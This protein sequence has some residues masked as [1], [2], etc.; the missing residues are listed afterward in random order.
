MKKYLLLILSSI[1][2]SFIAKQSN[3]D[4]EQ[5]VEIRGKKQFYIS[6]GTAKPVVVFI[7]GLG[8]TM[9]D[10]Q[11]VQTKISKY[12][13]TI[14]YDRA[15]IGKS[16]SFNNERNLENISVE[17]KE[18]VEKI[19]LDKPFVLVGHSRGGLIARYFVSKY[20]EKVCGLILI[21]P[22]IPEH[23]WKKRELRTETE[24]VEFDK[25]YNSFCSDSVNYTATIRNEFKNTFTT[26]SALVEG[27]G[28]P[29]TIP[30][31][32]IGSNKITKDKYSKEENRI[33]VEFLKSYLKINP[34]IKLILTNKSGHFIHDDEP[35]L[36]TKEIVA[37]INK[38]KADAKR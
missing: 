25:F 7:T 19:G 20:P 2:F 17:L 13:K 30:I 28:F 37:I 11:E 33:K 4:K 16:E 12:A 15:G 22:A 6:K 31:T 21:D 27:K 29:L 23:K 8:P 38:L 1:F 26:D 3:S 35:K 34:Q 18:L 5:F 36:V 9:D 14:C 24:K 32:L 10:F